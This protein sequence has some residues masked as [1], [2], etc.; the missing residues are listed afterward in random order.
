MLLE[1]ALLQPV[2]LLPGDD[3]IND[4]ERR[5]YNLHC[6]LLV[7]LRCG[8][9]LLY[10]CVYGNK[11]S[12]AIARGVAVAAQRK[13]LRVLIINAS[14]LCN[15]HKFR[16]PTTLFQLNAV[17]QKISLPTS[18]PKAEIRVVAAEVRWSGDASGSRDPSSGSR[19]PSP[20]CART[21]VGEDNDWNVKVSA[22]MQDMQEDLEEQIAAAVVCSSS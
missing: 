5:C 12:Q 3:A 10:K 4:H 22:H 19:N 20:S 9:I 2:L 11:R 8:E 15:K 14:N 16:W 13:G 18:L 6:L 7:R 1:L 17:R 21:V